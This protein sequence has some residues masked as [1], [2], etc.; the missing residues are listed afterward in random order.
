MCKLAPLD[1]KP[2]QEF[3]WSGQ[4]SLVIQQMHLIVQFCDFQLA[5]GCFR[6]TKTDDRYLASQHN[7]SA[8]SPNGMSALMLGELPGSNG[9]YCSLETL[10][11]I[12]I[13]L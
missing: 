10:S 6:Q 5:M 8:W 7:R 1:Y 4:D 2:F 11:L 9:N 12:W 13:T 3:Y